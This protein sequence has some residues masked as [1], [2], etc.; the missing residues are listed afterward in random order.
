MFVQ[1]LIWS[2]DGR[3]PTRATRCSPSLD[4]SLWHGMIRFRPRVLNTELHAITRTADNSSL[5]LKSI[6]MERST[7]LF[8][9]GSRS[10]EC[11]AR[12]HPL[13]RRPL[14]KAA[15]GAPR[16]GMSDT[17]PRDLHA[18]IYPCV[19]PAWV[20]IAWRVKST[21]GDVR[22]CVWSLNVSS[23]RSDAIWN[24]IDLSQH[25]HHRFA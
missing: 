10:G 6:C 8:D 25:L 4:W 22:D 5:P 23:A 14:L 2:N 24:L 11:R 9:G 15:T 12:A 13:G 17:T 21:R 19:T 16:R 3:C 18:W 20:L 7:T 1:H